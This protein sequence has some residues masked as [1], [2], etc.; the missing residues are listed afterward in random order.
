MFQPTL[1]LRGATRIGTGDYE[2][3]PFQPTLPLRGAT[4]APSRSPS[5]PRVSTHAPLAGSDTAS[6]SFSRAVLGFNPRSPCGERLATGVIGYLAATMFQPTLP[7]RGATFDAVN[8]DGL[9]EFQPTLPLRGATSWPPA[10]LSA[11]RGFNPRSPCGE[12]REP[13]P[14]VW[15]RPVSTHAP[16]AGS[17]VGEPPVRAVVDVST[18]APLAGSDAEDA[19]DATKRALFQPTLPLRGA[20]ATSC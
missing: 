17:D 2:G 13:L 14:Q 12:R 9:L 6:S 20:T 5:R 8:L 7:L 3:E 19:R 15:T 4:R 10:R 18:H 11:S 1:P 16:L